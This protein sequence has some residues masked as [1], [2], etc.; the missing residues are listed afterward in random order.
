MHPNQQKMLQGKKIHVFS[1]T[2]S[3]SRFEPK[4]RREV[5]LHKSNNIEEL[6]ILCIEEIT[7]PCLCK[8]HEKVSAIILSRGGNT[9]YSF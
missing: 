7:L 3:G 8:V 9:K 4:L 2:I 6:E 1:M 5:C